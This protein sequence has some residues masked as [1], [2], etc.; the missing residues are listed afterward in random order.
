M[1]LSRPISLVLLCIAFVPSLALG[2][3]TDVSSKKA[4]GKTVDGKKQGMWELR[5]DN[6][7]LSSEITFVD[8]KPIAKIIKKSRLW[9][10]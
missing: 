3:E 6:G 10:T 1:K 9:A 5:W 8:D 2:Q 4:T 7:N